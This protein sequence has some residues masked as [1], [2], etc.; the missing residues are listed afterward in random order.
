LNS[1]LRRTNA[2]RAALGIAALVAGTL[3]TLLVGAPANAS[4]A[5]AAT[6]AAAN[7]GKSAGTCAN[8]PTT[9]SLGGSQYEHS[10]AGGYSGGPEYWCADFAMW[11]WANS[12]LNTSGLTA[13]AQSFYSYGQSHGT[14]HSS[15]QPGDAIVY[16]SS[17]G[18]YA[19]HVAIV[20]A[21][22]A[23]GSVVTANG[24]WGGSSGTMAHFAVTS[25]VVKITIPASEAS[26]GS[27]VPAADYYITGIVGPSGSGGSSSP[28]DSGGNP[29]S[30]SGLCGSG[31]GVVDS[32]HITG[33][34]IFLLYD[35]STGNNCVVTLADA[36]TGAVSMN[37]TLTVQGGSTASDPGSYH[38]YAGPVTGYAP[39]ACVK[40]GG[41]Y[42]TSTWTSDYSHCGD[43]N[44]SPPPSSSNP[45]SA[46]EVC[47]S[48]YG[49]V[50]HHA[51]TG[52][53]VYLLYNDSNGDNC[54]VTLADDV[55]GA[56]SMNATLAVQGGASTSN[57]G[58]FTSYAG[59]VYES[60]PNS[61]V[62]WGGTYKTSTWTS[63]YGHCGS[64]SGSTAANPYTA[65]GV[66]GSGYSVID[67]HDLGS[68]TVYL[69]YSGGTNCVVTL[70][71]NGT[72]AVGLNATLA[73]QGGASAQNP[74]L[75]Q[76]YAGPVRLAAAG[77]CVEWGGSYESTGW[78]S[79]WSHC[80]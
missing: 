73:V 28:P 48:G 69:L 25:S 18:G 61:C 78:V 12:G 76:W 24:D 3:A 37:A 38:W 5:S 59:P 55:A 29:Y 50:D 45:Y 10:C 68:A 40:W 49:V 31:Y 63:E 15:A 58:S 65:A 22:N 52:A 70:V 20:T 1:P 46:G 75:F 9:N 39:N 67:S 71:H 51:L 62:K 64:G 8:R 60:A 4:A 79:G 42:K 41:T 34:T 13:A 7:I 43:G 32:H 17:R 30:G 27:W 72:G 6:L 66:C 23:D 35:D 36:D 21:V 54:V 14:L 19:N 47:G 56:V 57:P 11:A 33:A 53:T 44:G 80:G 74:G 2:L 77:D 26:T 16:S